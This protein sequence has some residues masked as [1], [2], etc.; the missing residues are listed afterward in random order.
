MIP[1]SRLMVLCGVPQRIIS[2]LRDSDFTDQGFTSDLINHSVYFWGNPGSGKTVTA[3]KL[4]IATM[5]T[6]VWIPSAKDEIL[7]V[8][9]SGSIPYFAQQYRFESVPYLL[10]TVRFALRNDNSDVLERIENLKRVKYLVLDDI[11]TEACTA[12]AYETL[13]RLID[14]R[15]ALVLPIVFTSNLSLNELGK[16]MGDERLVS[17]IREMC[18]SSGIIHFKGPD[19][20]IRADSSF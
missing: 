5:I 20:R 6:Q 13:Y 18:G 4:M 7:D 1:R 11:G 19:L 8:L 10:Q 17:R 14:S 16:K 9:G 15:Y 12:W 2:F 3:V